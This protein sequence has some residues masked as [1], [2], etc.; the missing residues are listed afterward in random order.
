MEKHCS[1]HKCSN[2]AKFVC[3]C[4]NPEIYICDDHI[5]RHTRSP[6]L[7]SI[8]SL[9]I[10]LNSDQKTSILPKLIETLAY[11]K[12]IKATIIESSKSL[13]H[14]LENET[15]KALT[16]LK[17]LEHG[18]SC[19][20]SDQIVSKQLYEKILTT[21]VDAGDTFLN[22]VAWIKE[23]LSTAYSSF[24]PD[25]L[26]WENCDEIIFSRDYNNG[27]LISI[28]LNTF[29]L[30]SLDFAPKIGAYCHECKI[31]SNTYFFH[32]GRFNNQ[33]DFRKDAYLIDIKSEKVEVLENGPGKDYGGAV[34]K[35]N[36]VYV[37]G[38]WCR[39]AMATCDIFDLKLKR[40][41]SIIPLPKASESITAAVL[42]NEII[43]SGSRLECCYSYDG[44]VYKNILDLPNGY[45]VVCKGW[46]LA[47][48]YLYENISENN[49]EWVA[50]YINNPWKNWL[51]TFTV[52]MRYQYFYF[53][54]G[55][56][57]LMRIDTRLKN[58]QEIGYN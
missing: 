52:F 19:L 38:G 25:S 28:S 55:N 35:G 22:Q 8:E 17:Y 3:R 33:K 30:A 13:I 50:Y 24:Y 47:S 51:W 11:I 58:L 20:I 27:G 1:E 9:L 26:T 7:H 14:L 23:D 48:S 57:L 37:F 42:N 12:K 6:G 54:D 18:C 16:N 21:K 46:I 44:L 49:S 32:G 45:K 5:A 4:I 31:D 39:E 29:K 2:Q 56:N 40:W 10:E 34:L 36:K 43:L 15:H 41:E 53:I